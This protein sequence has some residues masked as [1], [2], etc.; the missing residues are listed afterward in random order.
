MINKSMFK[1]CKKKKKKKKSVS[2]AAGPA[3]RV[4]VCRFYGESIRVRRTLS[5][6]QPANA[7][8]RDPS[9]DATV[10]GRQVFPL[11]VVGC[12]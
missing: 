11:D 9:W 10:P 1:T 2:L 12:R 5:G 8:P 7:L 4:V 3:G 6:V